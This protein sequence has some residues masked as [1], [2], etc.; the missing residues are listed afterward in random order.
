MGSL[1]S[2]RKAPKPFRG[3]SAAVPAR[4]AAYRA[5]IAVDAR[6]ADAHFNLARLY[7]RTGRRAAAIR[8]FRAYR[9]L[10]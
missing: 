9:D 3:A 6:F 2:R 4:V 8:H 10:I 1:G 7:E 5:A